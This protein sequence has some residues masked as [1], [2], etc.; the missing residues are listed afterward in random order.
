M[1]TSTF[2]LQIVA[3]GL[4]DSLVR[5]WALL[6]I[7][8]TLCLLIVVPAAVL[9]RYVNLIINIFDDT[10]PPLSMDLR[11]YDR[12]EGKPVVFRAFDGHAL[13]GMLL[14]GNSQQARRGMIVFAHEYGSNA[15]SCSRYCRP[16]LEAGYD[17][18]TFDF[19]GHGQSGGEEGYKPRQWASD[20]EL[21]DMLGAIA[22]VEDYLERHDYP[23]EIGLFGISRGG[24]A[25]IL[26]SVDVGSVKAILTDGAF[27][28][29]STLEYLMQRWVSIFAKVRLI[30]E[31]HP[32]A[33]W[34]FLRWLTFRECRRRFNCRYPS[35]RK[36]IGRIPDTPIFFIHGERDSYIPVAQSQ[37]LY[38]LAGEKKYLWIVPRAKH[39]QCVIQ[40]PQEYARRTVRFFDEHLFGQVESD[41]TLPQAGLSDLTQ[42]V[43][44]L[45]KLRRRRPVRLTRRRARR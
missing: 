2:Q 4:T 9:R 23:R 28:S 25:A 42:P 41:E 31:N 17:V 14:D 8:C 6:S 18:F 44:D 29:D 24:A 38:D 11:D 39:N 35:V 5:N 32:P 19:R 27:S 13:Q 36:A 22:F 10:P 20:R 21:A 15:Y 12:L 26:A 16:L 3:G 1:F 37:M 40:A 7:V 33:F 45:P 34:R 30:Y 43:A